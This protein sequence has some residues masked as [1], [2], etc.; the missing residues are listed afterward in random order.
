M[1][2]ELD[3]VEDVLRNHMIRHPICENIIRMNDSLLFEHETRLP[4]GN[5]L[6][7]IYQYN[8]T[9]ELTVGKIFSKEELFKDVTEIYKNHLNVVGVMQ[10]INE[11]IKDLRA[12]K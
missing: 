2:S 11:E 8:F 12:V 9:S 4:N 10:L 1:D 3:C 5:W 6:L 7:I